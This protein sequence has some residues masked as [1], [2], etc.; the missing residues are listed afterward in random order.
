MPEVARQL[1]VGAVVEGT[2]Q[3]GR[4]RVRLRVQLVDAR[5]DSTVWSQAY[6]RALRPDSLF[7][8]QDELARDIA[9]ALSTELA[10]RPGGSPAA[11]RADDLE[12]FRLV[13][14]GRDHLDR[15][16]E[17]GHRRAVEAFE[18]ATDRDPGY[19]R[20]WAGLCDS[21]VSM[22]MYGHGDRHD[23]LPQAQRAAHRAISL[24]PQAADA[25]TSLGILHVAY[26]DTAA[27]VAELEHAIRIQ[28]GHATAHSWLTWVLLIVG[29]HERADDVAG[30]TVELDPR[31]AEAHA[32]QALSQ[33]ALGRPSDGLAAA[34]RARECSPYTTAELYEG[35]CLQALGRHAQALA[36][37]APRAGAER[38]EPGVPWTACGPDAVAAVSMV[39]LGELQA[40]RR[41][42][43]DVRERRDHLGAVLV[44]L[45][46]GDVDGARQ[47][48]DRVNEVGQ[49]GGLV[50][51]LVAPPVWARLGDDLARL[52]GVV[53]RSWGEV[54]VSE[55]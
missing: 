25:R 44:Q 5:R 53:R 49:W 10:P 50:T 27:A 14:V 12:A 52:R 30:R 1:G 8:L 45:A 32:H 22:H 21:L 41:V 35:M 54:E 3:A 24:D 43:D 51:R 42:L 23:L 37:L 26:Q 31:S 28:P 6:D 40:A 13:A 46:M 47:Q 11:G 20:A 9:G 29:R 4:G 33:L 34:R 16:T 7:A 55:R 39:E 19:A 36:V 17:S 18:R 15:K 38:G 48:L 2:V